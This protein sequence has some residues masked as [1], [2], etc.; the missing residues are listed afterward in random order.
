M[1]WTQP[2]CENRFKEMY[3]GLEPFRI[4]PEALEEDGVELELLLLRRADHDLRPPGPQHGPVPA[5]RV[6]R[7]RY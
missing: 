2:V 6:R 7:V 5:G 1:T 4:K 3:L